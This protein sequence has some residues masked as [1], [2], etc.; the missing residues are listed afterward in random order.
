[1]LEHKG[2]TGK[3]EFDNQAGVFHGEVEHVR[4]VVTFEGSSVDELRQAFEAS[5]DDYIAMCEQR[6]SR[7]DR[8]YSGNF[9]MQIDPELHRDIAIAASLE[10]KSL[11][12]WTADALR[13]CV[14][15]SHRI[16]SPKTIARE[17]VKQT[18]KPSRAR[19]TAAKPAK[20]AAKKTKGRRTR[21]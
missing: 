9:L 2:Y 12:T 14:R 21:R 19:K 1:M 7:V 5:V 10:G 16:Y 11:T 6:R 15:R 8:P 17:A 4:D 3:V 18:A 13:D 20:K